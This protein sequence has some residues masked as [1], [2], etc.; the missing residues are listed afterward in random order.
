VQNEQQETD[1]EV[2]GIVEGPNKPRR[3]GMTRRC[4]R[5]V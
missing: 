1:K 2:F 5:M 3:Q 4:K